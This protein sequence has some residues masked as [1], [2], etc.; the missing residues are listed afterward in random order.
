[1]P[2][3][4]DGFIFKVDMKTEKDLQL[5]PSMPKASAS[6]SYKIKSTVF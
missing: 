1:M 5:P 2:G 6:I 4:F 3:K